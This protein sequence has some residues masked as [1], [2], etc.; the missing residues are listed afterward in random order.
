[1]LLFLR[2][3]G[4]VY[5]CGPSYYRL[6]CPSDGDMIHFVGGLV[7]WH[8][9]VDAL[10]FD[11]IECLHGLSLCAYGHKISILTLKLSEWTSIDICVLTCCS[12]HS[13]SLLCL[14]SCYQMPLARASLLIKF[15]KIIQ[16][17]VRNLFTPFSSLLTARQLN[18]VTSGMFWVMVITAAHRLNA[19][20]ITLKRVE[21]D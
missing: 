5:Y 18:E 2:S 8:E 20:Q 14:Q 21:K 1:M 6:H 9:C 12:L 13:S 15:V 4:R 19:W 11:A 16:E 3:S 7:L 17:F 10:Q